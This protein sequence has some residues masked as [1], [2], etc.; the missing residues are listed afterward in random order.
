MLT[1][2]FNI[3]KMRSIAYANG[4]LEGIQEG[5][6]KGKLEG[7]LEG[8][9]EGRLEGKLEAARK[10]INKGWNAEEVA[11]ILELDS[12]EVKSLG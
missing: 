11:E 1:N 2:E 10:F 7:R 5:E 9:L 4:K 6:L 12:N 3:D 8:K